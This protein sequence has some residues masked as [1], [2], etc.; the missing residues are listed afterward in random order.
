MPPTKSPEILLRLKL[1]GSVEAT[2]RSGKDV[3]PSSRKAIALLAYLALSLGQWVPRLR[4]AKL[5]WDG[6]EEQQQ[7]TC[8]RGALHDISRAMGPLFVRVVTAQRDR[9]RLI[10]QAVWVDAL[11]AAM[12][13]GKAGLDG[14]PQLNVFSGALLLDGLNGI[15]E[16]FDFWLDTERGG[17]EERIRRANATTIQTRPEEPLTCRQRIEIAR[18]AVAVD[19][20]NEEALRE[21]MRA[22][23]GSGQRAQA[24]VEY[25]RCSALLKSHLDVQLAPE[26]QRLYNELRREAALPQPSLGAG[27]AQRLRHLREGARAVLHVDIAQSG[28]GAKG[29]RR[30]RAR[31]LELVERAVA[32]MLSRF[33]AHKLECPDRGMLF[34]FADTHSAAA[35]A[36]AIKARNHRHNGSAQP[37]VRMGIEIVGADDADGQGARGAR[38][39]SRLAQPGE[40]LLA[41]DARDQLTAVLDAD[42]VDLGECSLDVSEAPV[43]AFRIEP[44]CPRDT[45][46]GAQPL[47]GRILPT[48]AVLPFAARMSSPEHHDLGDVLAHNLNRALSQSQ[49]L[50]V[51]AWQSS[52]VFRR[53]EASVAQIGDILK[54]NYLLTGFYRTSGQRVVLDLELAETGSERAVW[55]ERLTDNVSAILYG[56]SEMIDLTVAGVC[57]KILYQELARSRLQPLPTL[58][59]YTLLLGGMALMHRN[60]LQDFQAS[61]DMLQM[62]LERAPRQALPNAWLANWYVLRGQQGWSDDVKR[63]A[64]IALDYSRRSIDADPTC[65]L[66][67]TVDGLVHTTLLKRLDIGLEQYD[68]AIEAN[69]NDSLAWLL[70][71]TLH[72]FMGEGDVAVADTQRAL[73]LTPLDPHRYFYDSLS[74]TACL[75][76]HQYER[77]LE[78]A[79]RSLR[80]NRNKTSTLR[81]KAVAQWKLGHSEAARVTVSE[82]LALEPNLT[83]SSWLS[84]SPSATYPIGADWAHVFSELGIPN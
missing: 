26:T 43:R 75:A 18:K 63:D 19:P 10:P 41:A 64:R 28:R 52:S 55:C 44:P 71:G 77:A 76:A 38:L 47:H 30:E 78:L 46:D 72:A 73:K 4:I 53:R 3:L 7:R 65:S 25:E 34:E 79:N 23:A 17:L 81:A 39:M 27:L 21:L 54:A 33:G 66:A 22:L 2:D 69:P 80:V 84:R 45:I 13:A 36:L 74:A 42:I 51:I 57:R 70:R 1:I 50:D 20:M 82:L 8:L 24:V 32:G 59:T 58:E 15:G 40:I 67:L 62:V 9:L 37:I 29:G 5:L 6:A 56:E 49:N 14:A 11:A 31:M 35:V 68:L 60:S 83:I 61:H 48:I 12:P 16:E